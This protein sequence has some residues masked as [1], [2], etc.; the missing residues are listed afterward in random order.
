M[1]ISI[2]GSIIA[3]I[4]SMMIGFAWYSDALFGKRWR[5]GLGWSDEYMSN[6]KERGM[7]GVIIGGFLSEFVMAVIL[8]FMIQLVGVFSAPQAMTLA[9]WIWLGFIA[10]IQMGSVF[11]ERRSFGFYLINSLYRL[12]TLLVMAIILTLV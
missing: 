8:S 1:S 4:V 2:L 3:A 6:M 11:W 5:S 7:T 9:F 12:V 10:T